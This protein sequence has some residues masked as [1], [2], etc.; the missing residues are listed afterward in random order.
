MTSARARPYQVRAYSRWRL[1]RTS[2]VSPPC[3]RPPGALACASMVKGATRGRFLAAA[4]APGSRVNQR[5]EAGSSSGV[6]ALRSSLQRMRPVTSTGPSTCPCRREAGSARSIGTKPRL[7]ITTD[8][9]AKTSGVSTQKPTPRAGPL[10]RWQV[11]E[12]QNLVRGGGKSHAP[13]PGDIRHRPWPAGAIRLR[14]ARRPEPCCALRDGADEPL[15]PG[16]APHLPGAEADEDRECNRHR[17]GGPKDESARGAPVADSSLE[18][19]LGRLVRELKGDEHALDEPQ[20]DDAEE[21][22]ERPPDQEMQPEGRRHGELEPQRRAEDEEVADEDHE[23]RRAVAGVMKLE[24][25]GR[26]RTA[27]SSGDPRTAVPGRIA[28][29]DRRGRRRTAT[30]GA[31]W[32]WSGIHPPKAERPGQPGRS[33][34]HVGWPGR[35]CEAPG[36]EG[37]CPQT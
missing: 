35:Q 9:S 3:G 4:M 29:T 19:T 7:T 18:P 25:A 26:G 17:E 13:R 8:P 12:D 31:S 28:G 16:E 30:G 15:L 27:R 1:D 37:P 36:T 11:G 20:R 5:P 24:P 10:A 2:R 23:H 14:R 34:A 33:L 21:D 22:D 6:K 32:R